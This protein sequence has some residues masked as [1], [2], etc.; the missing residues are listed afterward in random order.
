MFAFWGSRLGAPREGGIPLA[1]QLAGHER[2]AGFLGRLLAVEHRPDL[3]R[4]GRFD[5]EPA[6]EPDGRAG[7]LDALRDLGEVG[8]DLLELAPASEAEPDAPVP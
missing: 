7:S 1:L 3:A 4:D 2:E 8:D 5:P 6:G